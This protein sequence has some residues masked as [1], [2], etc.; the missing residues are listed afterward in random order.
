ARRERGAAARPRHRA[1]RAIRPGVAN[2]RERGGQRGPRRGSTWDRA[3]QHRAHGHDRGRGPRRR[4]RLRRRAGPGRITRTDRDRV[5]AALGRR[6]LR[7]AR[8]ARQ[9]HPG[10]RDLPAT[11]GDRA[12]RAEAGAVTDLVLA[13]DHTVFVDALSTVL[14]RAGYTV[15]AI[16]HS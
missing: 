9:R 10:P 13:D 11:G 4:T 6:A 15:S 3:D 12:R 2:T 5:V 8:L 16:A 7:T 14:T 1:D